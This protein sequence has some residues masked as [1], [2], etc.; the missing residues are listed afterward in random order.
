MTF[1]VPIDELDLVLSGGKLDPS[2][3]Q[4]S[5]HVIRSGQPRTW[6]GNGDE[7]VSFLYG[8]HHKGNSY[9]HTM[10]TLDGS[11][12]QVDELP[13]IYALLSADDLYKEARV[14]VS[15]LLVY[16]IFLTLDQEVRYF[17]TVY[18][19]FVSRYIVLYGLYVVM[20]SPRSHTVLNPGWVVFF[21]GQ[22]KMRLYALYH[23]SKKLLI[24]MVSFFL[25]EISVMM[26]ILI[27]TNLLSGQTIVEIFS[28]PGERTTYLY[29]SDLGWNPTVQ[30][31]VLFPVGEV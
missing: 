8:T 22:Y 18:N 14:A 17:G 5:V 16:E 15:A 21:G 1:A 30:A 27:A 19:V 31:T 3:H 7:S 6:F 26:W 12:I 4:G 23:C 11:P 20:L 10:A 13:S 9:L 2:S 28:F 29:I 25:A 24:F